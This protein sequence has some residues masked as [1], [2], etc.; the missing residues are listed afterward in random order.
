MQLS[1]KD[2]ASL[3]QVSEDAIYR[4]VKEGAIPAH[5]LGEQ[6]R[7]SRAELLEWATSRQM[8]IAADAFQD[9]QPARAGQSG[10]AEALR[11]GGVLHGVKGGDKPSVLR[12]IIDR[13]TLPEEMDREFLYEVLLAREALG[14]TGI[15]G[16]IAIP[17]VRNPVI[18][19]TTR[20]AMTVCF[21][22][23]PIDFQAIDGQPVQT[24]FLLITP[25]IRSH[26]H[27]LS[28]LGFVLRDPELKAALKRQAQPE[29]LLT[30]LARV[31]AALARPG[32]APDNV[33]DNVAKNGQTP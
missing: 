17:H 21:L 15:G 18:L 3:L 2:A 33:A 4:W 31:E 23:Q 24:L 5:H 20:P 8:D 25:T 27:L 1:V 30:L 29:E 11:A 6:Y 26:L 12:G 28:R 14:S 32:N 7:F 22:E 10:L 19:H 16:G 13:L 9:G